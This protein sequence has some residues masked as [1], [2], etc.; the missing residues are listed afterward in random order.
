MRAQG[1]ASVVL[2]VLAALSLT[3][4]GC[5]S[6]GTV[7]PAGG[8]ASTTNSS[9]GFFPESAH[10][11]T[12][13]ITIKHLGGLSS[14]PYFTPTYALY[15]D[16][17]MITSA[18]AVPAIYPGQAVDPW[19]MGT[20]SE[21]QTRQIFAQAEALLAYAGHDLGQPGVA[22]APTTQIELTTSTGVVKISAAALDAFP[23]PTDQST[24]SHQENLTAQ[25]E[26]ARRLMQ[27]LINQLGQLVGSSSPHAGQPFA[28]QGYAAFAQ[29]YDPSA[30]NPLMRRQPLQW[31]GP[32]LP[33][34]SGCVVV[35]GTQLEKLTRQLPQASSITPWS[36]GGKQWS[37]SLRPLL[38]DEHTCA[39][40][41]AR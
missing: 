34:R 32:V 9:A 15:R 35:T 4:M 16:G 28:P 1:K 19:L 41:I 2:G 36:S 5:Q 23:L 20:V 7:S 13:L 10:A 3:L 22:D 26:Q 6:S 25:Q 12:A 18:V 39:D 27:A 17:R 33:A 8:G 40:V 37:L 14:T 24:A 30:I 11:D 29:P 21:Q 38:P 31:P